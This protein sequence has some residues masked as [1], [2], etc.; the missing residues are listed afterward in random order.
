MLFRSLDYALKYP[1]YMLHDIRRK[2]VAFQS[3]KMYG[4]SLD[5]AVFASYAARAYLVAKPIMSADEVK[6]IE[7]GYLKP[8]AELL[9][10]QKLNPNWSKPN[11]QV[12][13]NSGMIALGVAL[14]NDSIINIALNDPVQGYH[15]LMELNVNQDG[16][17]DEGSPTYHFYPLRAMLLSAEAVRCLGINLYDDKLYKM[18][19][20][21]ALSVYANLQL[22]AH[23][24]G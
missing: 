20:S 14:A 7:D 22:P 11:W 10:S 5:E 12:W 2:Q 6:Q 13:H 15:K 19:A 21:P 23:N 16:W 17:W 24:D 8:C 1:T 4:Q 18:F 9:L 3:G